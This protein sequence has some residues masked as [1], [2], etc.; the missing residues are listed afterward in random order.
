MIF[1]VRFYDEFSGLKRDGANR[2]GYL[3][4]WNVIEGPRPGICFYGNNIHVTAACTRARLI[5]YPA[6]SLREIR[7][8]PFGGAAELGAC[9][10]GALVLY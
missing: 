5:L 1:R 2:A 3:R 9:C 4:G 7:C 8:V 10:E 6:R